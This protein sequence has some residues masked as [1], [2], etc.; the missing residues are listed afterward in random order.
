MLFLKFCIFFNLINP[1]ICNRR[2]NRDIKENSD[3][4]TTEKHET[5]DTIDNRYTRDNRDIKE[6]T[7]T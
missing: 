5:T 7:E 4:R 3:K 2:N 6:T 1:L